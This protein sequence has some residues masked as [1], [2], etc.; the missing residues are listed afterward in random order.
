[1]LIHLCLYINDE[2]W[3]YLQKNNMFYCFLILVLVFVVCT[4]TE[5]GDPKCAIINQAMVPTF[6]SSHIFRPQSR[7]GWWF[8]RTGAVMQCSVKH[9]R[10][11]ETLLSDCFEKKTFYQENHCLGLSGNHKHLAFILAANLSPTAS[12]L[13][14]FQPRIWFLC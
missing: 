11:D 5:K 8:V 3:P 1:M 2:C 4:A 14:V 6:P 12:C 9:G 13:L 10:P 7:D